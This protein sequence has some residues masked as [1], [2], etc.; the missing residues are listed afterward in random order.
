MKFLKVLN[1][2]IQEAIAIVSS[3]GAGDGNKIVATDTDGRL[4]SSVMPVGFGAETK[5]IVASE[6][7]TA[8]DFVNIWNDGGTLKCRRADATNAR[9]AH[10]FVLAGVTAAAT[11][12]VY[13]GNLNTQLTGLTIGTEYVLSATTPGGVQSIATAIST[14]GYI[15]QSLGTATSATELLVE[16]Q[17]EVTLA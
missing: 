4:H 9:R 8:G 12:T 10:G 15:I 13:Y 1:N 17:N 5:S 2:K 7:L 6:N 3:A 11:A 14:T 16:I